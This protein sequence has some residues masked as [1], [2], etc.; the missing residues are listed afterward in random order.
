MSGMHDVHC[1]SLIC[2]SDTRCSLAIGRRI[3]IGAIADHNMHASH[4]RR[5]L[6]YWPKIAR[7][8][9]ENQCADFFQIEYKARM[10]ALLLDRLRE[11]LR[12]GARGAARDK[13][14]DEFRLVCPV[15]WQ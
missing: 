9:V 4:T 15:T 14:V 8:I 13:R 1:D 12:D 7:E 6:H 2:R 3:G 5:T 10:L 11:P